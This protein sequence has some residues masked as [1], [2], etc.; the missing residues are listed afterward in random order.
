MAQIFVAFSEKLNFIKSLSV[1]YAAQ[2]MKKMKEIAKRAAVM[3]SR[4]GLEY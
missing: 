4:V 1:L 2:N 3:I